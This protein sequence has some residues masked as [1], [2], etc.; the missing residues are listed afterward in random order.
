MPNDP[1][2]RAY[3]IAVSIFMVMIMALIVMT[4]APHY[5]TP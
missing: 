2:E 1:S 5:M 4:A 3:L